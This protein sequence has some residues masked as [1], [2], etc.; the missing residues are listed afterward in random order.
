MRKLSLAELV[1]VV[2]EQERGK[3][4]FL[5]E[6]SQLAM[7]TEDEVSY[8]HI[9]A[10][11]G[12]ESFIL[13]ETARAQLADRLEIPFRFAEHLR[14]EHPVLLDQ[15]VNTLFRSHPEKRLI[16]TLGEQCRA[17]LSPKYRI[18]D[19]F[20]FIG[21]VLPALAGMPDAEV[22][23]CFLTDTHMQLSLTFNKAQA[24]VQVGDPVC[25]GVL[26]QNS[27]VGVGSLSAASYIWRKVCGNG[28]VIP[29]V[30]GPA[31]RRYHLGKRID[32]LSRLPNDREVWMAYQDHVR[33]IADKGRFPQI[34]DRLQAAAQSPVEENPVVAVEKLAKRFQLTKEESELVLDRYLAGCENSLWGMINAVTEAAKGAET[35]QRRV[36]LQTIGG[37]MMLSQD[38]LA[39]A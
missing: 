17:I 35:V 39:A 10:G 2:G 23:E 30:D 21:A 5:V 9:P 18:L 34:V 15:T 14:Q 11:R 28:L 8:L 24:L 33:N 20:A 12:T 16:R 4:D 3:R 37:K 22:R 27:E 13:N 26:L 6:T 32:D 29:Q 1:Q 19:N 31:M 25:Y 7:K 38:C 36:D